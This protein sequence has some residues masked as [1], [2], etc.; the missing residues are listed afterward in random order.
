MRESKRFIYL[1]FIVI[2]LLSVTATVSLI[3]FEKEI[4][5]I[6][7]ILIVL[8]AL[9][10]LAFLFIIFNHKKLFS[11]NSTSNQL[12]KEN[13][14]TS[15]YANKLLENSNY[16]NSNQDSSYYETLKDFNDNILLKEKTEELNNWCKNSKIP[17]I[18]FKPIY[19]E[20][21]VITDLIFEK[22]N[23]FLNNLFDIKNQSLELI[24]YSEN[25]ILGE[26]DI[27]L[28]GI[29]D[30]SQTK[31]N[32]INIYNSVSDKHFTIRTIFL[33]KFKFVFLIEDHTKELSKINSLERSLNIYETCFDLS[34][35]PMVI[36]NAQSFVIEYCNQSCLQLVFAQSKEQV[37]GMKADLFLPLRQKNGIVSTELMISEL[38]KL[39]E[40]KIIK[41]ENWCL[42]KTNGEKYSAGVVFFKL[43]SDKKELVCVSIHDE[44][45]IIRI[46]E[47]Y[48]K[49]Q[50]WLQTIIDSIL[51][52]IV[53]KDSYGKVIACNNTF[54]SF[55]GQNNAVLI[56][57]YVEEIYTED[58]SIA[59]RAIDDEIIKLGI[60]RTYEQQLFINDNTQRIFLITKNPL[61]DSDGKVYAIV[62][63]GTDITSIKTLENKLY[64][65]QLEAIFAN[66]AKSEFLANMSHEIRTPIN[67]IIGYS[68]LLLKQKHSDK[69]TDYID[70]IHNSGNALLGLINHIL[71]LSKI[72]AGKVEVYYEFTDIIRVL[73][74]IKDIFRL[75]A[76]QKRLDF[77]LDIKKEPDVWFNIDVQKLKQ[78]L[79]NLIGNAI[80]FTQSGHVKIVFDYEYRDNEK[81]DV[82]IKIIDTGIGISKK[83]ER[84]L[85]MPFSQIEAGI[86]STS[87]GSG[88]GS[89]ISRQLVELLNGK[90]TLKSS[91]DKGSEFTITLENVEITSNKDGELYSDEEN[92]DY[93]FEK[94]S[95]LLID[96]NYDNRKVVTDILSDYNFELFEGENGKEG[97]ELTLKHKPD[98]ILLDIRMPD[99]D[100]F[101]V[102]TKIREA[103]PN[104][105]TTIIAYTA[106]ESLKFNQDEKSEMFDDI[107]IKPVNR[108]TLLKLLAKYIKNEIIGLENEINKVNCEINEN[109]KALIKKIFK[110]SEPE[111]VYTSRE[112]KDILNEIKKSNEYKSD[113]ELAN[114]TDQFWAAI[115]D[116]NV[117]KTDY[118]IK[119]LKEIYNETL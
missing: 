54:E 29:Q 8:D 88:L 110:P 24:Q 16:E 106:V 14:P 98:L 27:V 101:Q 51:S 79:I 44:S 26:L 37:I 23:S 39:N 9:I 48:E 105:K 75:Q 107:L 103:I 112:L 2:L 18:I 6:V 12:T 57:K 43:K 13:S 118:F 100:G 28:A 97:L 102:A 85:F 117:V 3:N 22:T 82:I 19:A 55:F 96:D 111:Q 77:I 25:Q 66:N 5:N 114:F 38:E 81:T 42:I 64:E 94:T 56:G 65:A 36:V 73:K 90:I 17:F 69:T 34:D 99:I 115:D 83:D 40:N 20:N 58:E 50:T 76:E 89:I 1:L 109:S 61:I 116:F 30:I 72:E 41:S 46:K 108:N 93:V 113:I 78:I 7:W 70:S 84:K 49:S 80:K 62:A 86:T 68:E 104:F 4:T 15:K 60:K 52:I 47:N 53:V 71:E 67:A 119:I 74:S 10:T 21:N 87:E 32:I 45:N 95:I 11:Y 91:P 33:N 92:I 31:F 63:N 59:I 35:T